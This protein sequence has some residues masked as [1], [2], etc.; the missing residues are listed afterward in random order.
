MNR[1][2]NKEDKI[3]IFED[4]KQMVLDGTIEAKSATMKYVFDDIVPFG[5]NEFDT[6]IVVENLDTV[7]ALQK[8]S[9]IGKTCLLNMASYKRPGGGVRNGA[10]AQEECLFRCSNLFD[11]ISKEYYPILDNEAIYTYNSVFF[12][13]GNYGAIDPIVCDVVTIAAVNLNKNSYYDSTKEDWVDGIVEKEDTHTELTKQKIRLM[14]SLAL[15]NEVENMVLGAWGCG[16]FKNDPTEMATMF[17][18]VI[19]E[20]PFNKQFRNISFAVINDRNSVSNNYSIFK[21][22]LT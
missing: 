19:A 4:T 5:V 20:K 3:A 22:I 1:K 13:D 10:Q 2:L 21:N 11:V 15:Q 16:V 14:L 18:E 9:E 7:S 12:K 8:Y 17:K 6:N